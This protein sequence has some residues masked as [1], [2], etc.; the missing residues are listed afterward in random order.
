MTNHT[1]NG[2]TTLTD[3]RNKL[4]LTF[5]EFENKKKEWEAEAKETQNDFSAYIKEKWERARSSYHEYMAEENEEDHEYRDAMKH[6][7]QQ[8]EHFVKAE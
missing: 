8:F 6:R 2:S 3:L 7:M 4:D 1:T 5:T